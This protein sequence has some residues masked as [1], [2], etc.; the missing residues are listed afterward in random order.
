VNEEIKE[1]TEQQMRTQSPN[2]QKK[3]KQ[4]ISAIKLMVAAFWERAGELMVGIMQQESTV[5]EV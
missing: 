4:T 3:F 2:N 5:S 1:Q